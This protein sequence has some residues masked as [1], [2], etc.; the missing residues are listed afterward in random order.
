MTVTSVAFANGEL[1]LRVVRHMATSEGLRAVFVHPAGR[2]SM[3]EQI[4]AIAR[5]ARVPVVEAAARSE[6]RV[7]QL[8]NVGSVD[9]GVSAGYG[10]IMREQEFEFPRYGTVN[11]HTSLL[12]HN[13]GAHPN[14][15]AIADASPAGATLHFVVAGV[16]TGDI[17]AQRV[18]EYGFRDTARTLYDRQLLDAE[19][20]FV[21]FW[22]KD[23]AYWTNPPRVAQSPEG[24]FH[25][26]RDL[27]TLRLP[28]PETVM[29]VGDV[30]RVIRSR[31]FAPFP[32]ALIEVDGRRYRLRMEIEEY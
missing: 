28:G 11:L 6:D 25:R 20:L 15:W 14:A 21:E 16:D 26:V 7:R 18:T 27:E 30:L 10:F 12:P 23:E 31:T 4:T 19:R 5:T 3:R 17:L 13:R 32:G 24:T 22:P 8:H 2:A 9:V 1:G 29:R